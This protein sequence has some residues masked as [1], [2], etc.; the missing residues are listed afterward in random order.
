VAEA[1]VLLQQLEVLRSVVLTRIADVD[2]RSLHTVADAPSTSSWLDAQH[3]SLTRG[4]VAFA[5]RLAAFPALAAAVE[6]GRLSVTGAGRVAA[7][8]V[9]AR[10][11][12]DRPDG[13]VD[14]QP[15]EQTIT[16]VVV[17][18]VLTA[19]CQ[20]QAGL[21]DDDPRLTD[22]LTR[23]R[24]IATRSSSQL[25]RLTDALLLLAT[26]VEPAQLPGALG[27]LLDALLPNELERRAEQ[28]H[29]L[30][31]YGCGARTTAPAG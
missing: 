3:T 10:P 2:L 31:A 5:R 9:K 8:L 28:A 30:A 11:H 25:D 12:L 14:G 4:E 27:L 24:A 1:Q 13:L 6:A 7:A 18:G 26:H 19:V 16:A 29:D 23:L 20:A 21:P 15:G 22:L 17:D